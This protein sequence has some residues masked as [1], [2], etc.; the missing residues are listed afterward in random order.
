MAE[1]G[2]EAVPPPEPQP[3]I[4][5]PESVQLSMAG[6]RFAPNDL[7]DLKTE[8]GRSLTD[9]TGE[10]AD[11]ADRFQTMAWLRLRRQGVKVPWA[12]CGDIELDFEVEVEEDPM[13][14]E[15]SSSSPASADSGA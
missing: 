8:T 1:S 7:R 11:D 4:E 3:E 2:L 12:E 14:G 13:S 6:M 15:R 10:D 9:L 5:V